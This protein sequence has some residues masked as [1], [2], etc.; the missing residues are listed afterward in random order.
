MKKKNWSK[1]NSKLI[2]SLNVKSVIKLLEQSKEGF[3]VTLDYAKML[4]YNT[5]S[6]KAKI[7]KVRFIKI[8][9]L[10][11]LKG[12]VKIITDWEKIFV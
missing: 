11:S 7:N 10:W 4:R 8:K 12:T 9:N 5:E 2:I 1:F 3:V 6:T